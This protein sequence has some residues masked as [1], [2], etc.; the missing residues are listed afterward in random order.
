M[1][2]TLVSVGNDLKDNKSYI[3][4]GAD[5]KV[6]AQA[7]DYKYLVLPLTD[8]YKH[9]N[10]NIAI[11]NGGT[12]TVKVALKNAEGKAI[13][14]VEVPFTIAEP[15]SA[16][17]AS[18]YTPS[19]KYYKD[20]VFTLL[21]NETTSTTAMFSAGTF[22]FKNAQAKD[23]KFTLTIADDKASASLSVNNS[24]EAGKT[25]TLTGAKVKYINREYPMGDISVK[26]AKPAGSTFET[27]K[28]LVIANNGKLV[29]KY[30]TDIDNT[31]AEEVAKYFATYKVLDSA[32][33]IVD[34]TSVAVKMYNGN[35]EIT[36]ARATL[37]TDNKDLTINMG[38]IGNT[39]DVTYT[40]KLTIN[41][42]REVST[43]IVI[44]GTAAQ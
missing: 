32:G 3:W 19:A 33:S 40:L 43:P 7:K 23:G 35:T 31:N 5:N 18:A 24:T 1:L 8:D 11:E 20:G 42:D 39:N 10:Q 15:S 12:Y 27:T 26:F 25:Y 28:S 16:S 30:L 41:G 14:Y 4:L 38:N 22:N 36:G 37:A 6:A 17:I 44:K 21:N 29:L 34:V 2:I 9:N 13:A